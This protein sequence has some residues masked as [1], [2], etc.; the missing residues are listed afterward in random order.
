MSRN[1]TV[2]HPEK[3]CR[4]RQESQG[5]SSER[6]LERHDRRLQKEEQEG[7]ISRANK[8]PCEVSR[9]LPTARPHIF[10]EQSCYGQ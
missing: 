3:C 9:G 4:I 1:R 2:Q 5:R 8:A 7:T 10:V 6:D